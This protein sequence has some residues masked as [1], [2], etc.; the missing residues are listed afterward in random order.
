[1]GEQRNA[2]DKIGEF[3]KAP[4][5]DDDPLP[6]QSPRYRRAGDF[7]FLSSTSARESAGSI[8]G[9]EVDERGVSDTDIGLQTRAAIENIRATLNAAGH[10][11]SDLVEVGCFL[12]TMNDFGGFNEVWA[13]YFDETGPTRT[14]VAVH[15]LSHPLLLIEL[16]GIAYA[17]ASAD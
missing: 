8:V 6:G 7:L 5:G 1:M 16:R 13:E 10:D 4:G 12:V 15:Q 14:T 17:P 11:L 2:K 3:R 9:A